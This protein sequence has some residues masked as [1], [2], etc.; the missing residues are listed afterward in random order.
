[1]RFLQHIEKTHSFA[2]LRNETKI[3]MNVTSEGDGKNIKILS[4]PDY[5]VSRLLRRNG[6][7]FSHITVNLRE[8]YKDKSLDEQIMMGHTVWMN[9][10]QI[11]AILDRIGNLRW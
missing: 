1:M 10:D 5:N 8:K 4:C 6:I 7:Y 11:V 9:G 3:N 2:H